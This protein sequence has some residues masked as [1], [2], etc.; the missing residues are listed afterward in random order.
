MSRPILRLLSPV[1]PKKKP[2]ATILALAV[3]GRS[4]R[5]A[6]GRRMSFKEEVLRAVEIIIKGVVMDYGE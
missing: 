6:T 1:L 5:N 3:L 2:A 4:I